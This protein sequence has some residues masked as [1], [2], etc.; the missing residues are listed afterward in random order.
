MQHT[1]FSWLSK[2]NINEYHAAH[3]TQTQSGMLYKIDCLAVIRCNQIWMNNV[4]HESKMFMPSFP[5]ISFISFLLLFWDLRLN[6]GSLFSFT[7][8]PHMYHCI[9]YYLC[10]TLKRL[11]YF[12]SWK[13]WGG[14]PIGPPL[15]SRP[16]IVRSPQK[17]AQW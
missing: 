12:G 10:L 11:G 1:C 2:Q 5:D 15:R 9:P 16:W 13:Y 3:T 4:P 8:Y 14:G 6:M 7:A 17:F